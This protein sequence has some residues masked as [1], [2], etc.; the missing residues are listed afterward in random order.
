[1]II[2]QGEPG[3]DGSKGE[4]VSL[5]SVDKRDEESVHCELLDTGR[6][7]EVKLSCEVLPSLFS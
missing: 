3:V 6:S 5:P 7:F 1:M 2:S 4:K